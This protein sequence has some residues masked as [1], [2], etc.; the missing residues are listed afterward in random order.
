MIIFGDRVTFRMRGYARHAAK[1]IGLDPEAGDICISLIKDPLPE[2][3][4]GH[5]WGDTNPLEIILTRRTTDRELT[6]D[7]I[8]KT[9]GHEMAHAKQYLDGTLVTPD[10]GDIDIWRGKTFVQGEIDERDAPWEIQA[11]QLEEEI[12][13][14]YINTRVSA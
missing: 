2:G 12:F 6:E 1:T 14:G 11:T 13:E 8:L 3:A 9:L 7:E 10:E 5:C 4:Y